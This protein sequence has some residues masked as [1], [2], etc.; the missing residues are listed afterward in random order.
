MDWRG[1]SLPDAPGA[2]ALILRLAREIRL[3][4]AT[5][6]Y[7]VLHPGLYLYAGS[8]W[9]SGGIRARVGRHLRH[10]KAPHWHIDRLTEAARVEKVIAF[11][12]GR[13]CAIADFA[14]AHGARAPVPRFG[15]SDCRRCEAH[16]LAVDPSLVGV[17]APDP[18]DKES[19]LVKTRI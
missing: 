19:I 7:P 5:L 6:R 11:P 2:Y 12:A 14:L 3:D 17:L 18:L 13:E 8:A 4:I 15:A 9:G 1:L 10:P 16:L